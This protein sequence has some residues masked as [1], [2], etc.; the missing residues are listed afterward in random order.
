MTV[1]G[2]R[3]GTF[4]T[5]VDC[6]WFDAED[7]LHFRTF[8]SGQ[9]DVFPRPLPERAIGLNM[10]VRLRSRGPVMTVRA[11]RRKGRTA[12]ADCGWTGPMQ[13]ERRRLFPRAALVLTLLERFE[14]LDGQEL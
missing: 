12:F 14:A 13:A 4:G 6:C 10:E 1:E 7:C 5:E 9:L 2:V 3:V 11:L 8:P